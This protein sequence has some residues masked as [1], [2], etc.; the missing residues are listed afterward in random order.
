VPGQPAVSADDIVF[1]E[2]VFL[3]REYVTEDM[4]IL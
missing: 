3:V 4:E 1:F 2:I